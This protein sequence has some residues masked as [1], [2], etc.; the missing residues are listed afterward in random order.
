M[1]KKSKDI[2]LPV[3]WVKTI[4]YSVIV[5]VTL[6]LVI[7]APK[8][9]LDEDST[10]EIATSMAILED[11]NLLLYDYKV[12]GTEERF[13]Q[14]M[15]EDVG[16]VKEDFRER[17]EIVAIKI[18]GE[19]E[20]YQIRDDDILIT[21]PDTP[22]LNI[23]FYLV[24]DLT[25][26][27]VNLPARTFMTLYQD[28]SVLVNNIYLGILLVVYFSIFTPLTIKITRMIVMLKKIYHKK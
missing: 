19:R 2:S 27:D 12:Y 3:L 25:Y 15:I 16:Q 21:S 4:L 8:D 9:I 26:N 28:I 24:K 22:E 6:L 13:N 23:E 20:T 18:Y 10:Y 1:A 14:G 5:L 17:H 11:D 7:V